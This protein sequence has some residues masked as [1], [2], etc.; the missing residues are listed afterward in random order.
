MFTRRDFVK[1]AVVAVA[2]SLLSSERPW[3]VFLVNDCDYIAAKSP[4]EAKAWY[5][6]FCGVD[7]EEIECCSLDHVF[8]DGKRR[9]TFA[10][11]IAEE[12]AAGQVE[13]FYL[14]T[15]GHYC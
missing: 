15:D 2:S 1:T 13:P 8:A 3:E 14:A 7:A 10:Q 12:V 6:E 11:S 5:L 9:L 4:E